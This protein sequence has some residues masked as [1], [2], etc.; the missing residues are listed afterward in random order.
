MISDTYFSLEP[1][2][3]EYGLGIP[4][5]KEGGMWFASDGGGVV[6][7]DD[8]RLNYIVLPN[9]PDN[10]YVRSIVVDSFDNKWLATRNGLSIIDVNQK[11]QIG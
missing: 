7:M 4:P 11:R 2:S 1:P 9:G 6:Y 5:R 10:N 8:T 3:P